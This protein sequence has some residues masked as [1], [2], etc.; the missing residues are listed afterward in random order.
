[1]SKAV[2]EQLTD[3]DLADI[4]LCRGDINAVAKGSVE[5]LIKRGVNINKEYFKLNKI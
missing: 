2:I 1:M 4:G 5:H 3:K